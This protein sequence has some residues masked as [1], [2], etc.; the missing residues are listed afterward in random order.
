MSLEQEMAGDIGAFGAA[1]LQDER[2]HVIAGHAQPQVGVDQFALVPL[3]YR[4]AAGWEGRR[5]AIVS[6]LPYPSRGGV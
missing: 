1:G 4:R 2:R 5:H 6:E 3:D